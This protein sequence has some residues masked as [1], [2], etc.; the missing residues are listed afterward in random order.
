MTDEQIGSLHRGGHDPLKVYNAYKA[1]SNIPAAPPLSW[2]RPSR[3]TG[4]AI[5]GEAAIPRTSKRN[6]TRK[7]IEHFRSRF[8]IPIPDEAARDGA[9]YRPPDSSPEMAYMQERRRVL[10]GYLPA[11]K[12]GPSQTKAPGLDLIEEFKRVE[13][14]ASHVDHGFRA[15]C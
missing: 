5:S 15:A 11:R 13:G 10:G 2:P 9:F 6:S 14:A 8:E 1:P 4:W 3:A 12:P 7:R